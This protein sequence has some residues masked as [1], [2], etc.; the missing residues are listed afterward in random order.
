MVGV[1]WP[2]QCYWTMW[3]WINIGDLMSW[4]LKSLYKGMKFYFI[5]LLLNNGVCYTELYSILHSNDVHINVS[6]FNNF[7]CELNFDGLWI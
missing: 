4:I 7:K 2:S 6:G 3:V 1:L 5:F